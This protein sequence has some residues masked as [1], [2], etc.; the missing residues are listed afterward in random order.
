MQRG[1]V[2]LALAVQ[3]ERF[4]RSRVK[5]PQSLKDSF[6]GSDRCKSLRVEVEMAHSLRQFEGVS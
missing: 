5:W 2:S 6:E 3:E 4:Q 1:S